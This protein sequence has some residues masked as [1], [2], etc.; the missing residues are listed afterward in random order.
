LFA[1]LL[2]P[3]LLAGSPPSPPTSLQL[4]AAPN[5]ESITAEELKSKL[6]KN[7]LV[8]ILDVRNSDAYSTSADRIKG[9]IHVKTRRLK[10]R[11]GMQPLKGIPRDRTV[12]T[13]CSCP[14]DESA[15]NAAKILMDA[16]FTQVRAL[17]GGW[18]EWMK[19]KGPTEP[20]PKGVN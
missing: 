2:M 8:T 19:V 9:A 3:A 13:Y 18:Q 15:L 11:L 14:H 7:E 1:F 12:V 20:R 6:L 17:R 4:A 10:Y 5:I 16:G